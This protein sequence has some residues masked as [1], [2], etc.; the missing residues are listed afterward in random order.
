[1][2]ML[3]EQLESMMTKKKV[4]QAFKCLI[5]FEMDFD[6]VLGKIADY[7]VSDKVEVENFW[8]KDTDKEQS[9]LDKKAQDH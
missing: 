6:K 5:D 4:I 3:V 1:M 2:E 9:S 8:H 7:M